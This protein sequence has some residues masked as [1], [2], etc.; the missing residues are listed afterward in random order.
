MKCE[1]QCGVDN[2]Q[3]FMNVMSALYAE[4]TKVIESQLYLNHIFQYI[5]HVM[6]LPCRYWLHMMENSTLLPQHRITVH[7]RWRGRRH[8]CSAGAVLTWL[9]GTHRVRQWCQSHDFQL[10][11]PVMVFHDNANAVGC[12]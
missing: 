6:E 1:I 2:T 8:N 10:I 3:K 4:L 9:S 11:Y 5:F 7:L 12:N